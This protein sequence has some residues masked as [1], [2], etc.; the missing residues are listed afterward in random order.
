LIDA[1]RGWERLVSWAQAGQLAAVAEFARRR[2]AGPGESGQ[3][4]GVSE[5]AVDELTAALRLSRSAAGARLQLAVELAER[6]PGTAAALRRGEIDLPRSRAMVD[7]IV[8]LEP[9][10]A[11]EVEARVLPRAAGQTVGQLRASLARAVLSADPAAAEARHKRA[12]AGRRVTHTPLPDGM[13]ELYA[14]LPAD[15]ACAAFAA[16]DA[17]ARSVSAGDRS[18]DARRADALVALLTGAAEQPARPLV[19]VTVPASTLLGLDEE[20][21]ELAGHGPVP[22][23]V[24]RRLAADP[25][26][27]WRRIL[28]DPASGAVLD[29]GRTTYRP[30][31]AIARHVAARDGT[32]RFPGCRQPARR[33]DLDHVR[34]YPAGRTAVDNLITL[35]RHH[36]RLKH[37]GRWRVT[38]ADDGT[39][40]WTPP[41]GHR[42]TTAPQRLGSGGP[43][44]L[45]PDTSRSVLPRT[46]V[47]PRA[48]RTPRSLR[49]S[50]STPAAVRSVAGSNLRRSPLSGHGARGRGEPARSG[51]DGPA[52][53]R[54][55]TSGSS[56]P[57]DGTTHGQSQ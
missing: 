17:R 9:A 8:P 54:Q 29:V 35:C 10:A 52:V 57:A 42:Y 16:I 46:R 53:P 5:F 20:P 1:V 12:V 18:M 47:G 32:C 33:C 50:S 30:P 27:T 51:I 25:A 14:L 37:S 56:Q 15:A 49:A 4:S 19:H 43:S 2:P 28:T 6:L 48:Y 44:A 45:A 7:G 13:G 55:P 22:A 23:P 39:V 11:A 24:A 21:G 40:T 26:G 3:T 31:P 41:T 34:P 36:H 38:Q